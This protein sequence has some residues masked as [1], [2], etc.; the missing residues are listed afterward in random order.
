MTARESLHHLVDELP[1]SDL[2]TAA[3]VL[4]AL[5]ATGDPVLRSLLAAPADD[6]PDE[7]DRDGGLSE[8]RSEA[9]G[10]STI[11]HDEVK[12]LLGLA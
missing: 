1:E 4:E 11:S 10:G 8:A 7:D 5:S 12:R 3:R 6:E 2:G 9:L